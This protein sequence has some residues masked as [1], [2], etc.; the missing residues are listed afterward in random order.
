MTTALDEL[1]RSSGPNYPATTQAPSLPPGEAA[2]R[3]SAMSKLLANG[4]D[5]GTIK[6]TMKNEFGMSTDQAADLRKL[7]LIEWQEEQDEMRPH[8]KTMA[9]RR[10]H[11]HIVAAAGKSQYQAVASLEKVLMDVQGTAEPVQVNVNVE[12]RLTGAVLSVL[13]QTDPG[14]VRELIHDQREYELLQ[15]QPEL[16]TQGEPVPV[17]DD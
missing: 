12:H 5:I 17:V 15:A 1:A 16:I 6:R 14:V 9:S 11:G 13:G 3:R 7:T 8:Q 2:K 10:L 4:M